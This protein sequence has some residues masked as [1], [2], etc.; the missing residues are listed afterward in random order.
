MKQAILIGCHQIQ[1]P[2][3]PKFDSNNI[4]LIEPDGTP[5]GTR[6]LAP[7]PTLLRSKLKGM[8]KSKGPDYTKILAIATRFV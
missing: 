2:L 1:R 6:I 5:I 4:V 3:V 7:I 8:S